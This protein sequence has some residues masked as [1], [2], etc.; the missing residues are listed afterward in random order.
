MAL[1]I[2]TVAAIIDGRFTA[3]ER[4]LLR[5]AQVACGRVPDERAAERLRRAYQERTWGP[6]Y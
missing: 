1:Q 5:D 4:R 6:R 3:A 2:V